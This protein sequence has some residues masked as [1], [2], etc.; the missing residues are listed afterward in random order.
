MIGAI[1][2]NCTFEALTP[3]FIVMHASIP[4]THVQDALVKSEVFPMDNKS[5]SYS[6]SKLLLR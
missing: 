6:S 4:G 1:C 2:L 5:S 3:Q